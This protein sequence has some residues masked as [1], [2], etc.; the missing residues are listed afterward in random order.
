[1]SIRA[2]ALDLAKRGVPTFRLQRGKKD[3]FVD[4]GWNKGGASADPITVYDRFVRPDVNMGVKC[5]DGV[6]V[7]DIDAH[8]GGEEAWRDLLAS[9]GEVPSTYTVATPSGGR[10]LYFDPG[11]ERF[12]QSPLVRGKID[13][14]ASGGY[15]VGAGSE[16]VDDNGVH[17]GFYQRVGDAPIAPLPD[18]LRMLLRSRETAN[19]APVQE[20]V[21]LDLPSAH[22]EAQR[23]LVS[24]QCPTATEGERNH[25]RFAVALKMG[26][27][28]LGE[29]AALEYVLQW[30]ATHCRPPQA[31][32]G[33]IAKT[34]HNAYSYRRNHIGK[35]AA[36]HGFTPL[37]PASD[38]PA[39]P[40]A[41]PIPKR[42]RWFRQ[43]ALSAKDI[44][45]RQWIAARRLIRG[46]V[47]GL[48][49]PGGVGK[50]LIS[51][52]WAAAIALGVGLCNGFNVRETTKVLI[53]NNEDPQDELDRRA[54]AVFAGLQLKWAD[55]YDR[56]G[57]LSGY[58]DPVRLVGRDP[59]T[60]QL[61]EMPAVRELIDLIRT[62]EIGVL[63]VDPVISTHSGLDE[64]SNTDMDYL[65]GAYRKIAAET[66]CA[67][68]LVHHSRKPAQGSSN[69]HV[70]NIDAGRG[71]SAIKDAM[72]IGLTFFTMSED[73]AETYGVL[74][75]ERHRFVRLDETE[76][77]NL[78]LRRE[79]PEWY[80]R[81]SITLTLSDGSQEDLGYLEHREL[82]PK[83]TGGADE[84]CELLGPLIDSGGLAV[85]AAA[86]AAGK[87]KLLNGSK[88][89]RYAEV[90]RIFKT[91]QPWGGGVIKLK[92]KLIFEST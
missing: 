8:H 27:F 91:P 40:G 4:A 90:R 20:V 83:L 68:L 79:V 45:A 51:I 58:G 74:P 36:G 30:N 66:N 13:I 32:A 11:G 64:N 87:A 2:H 85:T 48:I 92:G 52:Q 59:K 70:G 65:I 54:H 44:K 56:V 29:A 7:I 76:K 67:I 84:L 5:G 15:V 88:D 53:V 78:G 61:V 60:R 39:Q 10:H 62:H 22:A 69:G 77:F 17:R 3:V 12:G 6:I 18:N 42:V 19:L 47:T 72:R 71:A 38:R 21:E 9:I 14:R 26:D 16:W 33:R 23:Y 75:E 73:D 34:V 81:K 82:A 46:F 25:A 28:G 24:A 55:A 50:S 35:D 49:A 57:F 80:Y 86:E 37:L 63:M 89:K 1:M 31:D 43:H 41:E